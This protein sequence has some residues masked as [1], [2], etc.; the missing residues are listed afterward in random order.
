[1]VLLQYC[2][3]VSQANFHSILWGFCAQQTEKQKSGL[4]PPSFRN[5]TQSA[6][7]VYALGSQFP[8]APSTAKEDRQEPPEGGW[9]H[10]RPVP[11]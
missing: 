6:Y 3:C 10:R 1:M 4:I 7:G 2:L 8:W 9:A 5:F 11:K